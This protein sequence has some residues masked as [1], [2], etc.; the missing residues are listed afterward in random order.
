MRWYSWS[1]TG[2]RNRQRPDHEGGV[3]R[4]HR[5]REQ[6]QPGHLLGAARTWRFR[7]RT[8]FHHDSARTGISFRRGCRF[9]VAGNGDAVPGPQR[10]D[11]SREIRRARRFRTVCDRNPVWVFWP[12]RESPVAPSSVAVLPF[13]ALLQDQSNPA[14]ELGMT[15]SLIGQISAIPGVKVSSA[16]IACGD[17]ALPSRTRSLPVRRSTSNPCLKAMSSD[18]AIGCV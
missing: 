3:A 11:S 10:V 13:K 12:K 8:A 2:A 16:W 9:L 18:K 15:N 6:P 14:L 17:L 5:R 1:N 4:H 7:Q